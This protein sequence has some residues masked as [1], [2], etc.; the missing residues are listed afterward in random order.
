MI[1]YDVT[2]LSVSSGLYMYE[3][4]NPQIYKNHN[5]DSWPSYM[6]YGLWRTSCCLEKTFS[7]AVY[8]HQAK[9]GLNANDI[10]DKAN[11]IKNHVNL[12]KL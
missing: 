8:S 2:G 5:Y 3:K 4:P 6:N 7:S 9:F 1:L 10:F 12:L 11:W